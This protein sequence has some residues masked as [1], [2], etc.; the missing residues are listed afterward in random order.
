MKAGF[1]SRTVDY[2]KAVDDVSFNVYAGQTLGLV[3]E[4]GCGK[5]TAGR[6]ILKLIHK[7]AGQVIYDG[8]DLDL[9]DGSELRKLRSRIQII[10]QD[11]YSSLNPRM[12]VESML[13]EPMKVHGYG[14]NQKDRQRPRSDITR[15][16]RFADR[17]FR[18]LS[19]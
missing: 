1:F 5:T 8:H 19:A 6:S 3:G 12:T 7:T 18:T 16:G 17:T 10:F 13:M 4:S 15:R 14:D 2:V 11:P 9:L